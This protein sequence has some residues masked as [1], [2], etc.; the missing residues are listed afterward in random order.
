MNK[1][2]LGN[3]K[4][5][6]KDLMNSLLQE[7]I[8]G[9]FSVHNCSTENAKRE[10]EIISKDTAKGI[11]KDFSI[12]ENDYPFDIPE[13]WC[14]CRLRSLCMTDISYGIIKLFNED[15]NGVRVLRCSDV[16]ANKIDLSNVRT[17]SKKLSDE[18][19]RTILKGGEIVINVRG[20]LGGCSVVPQELEGYNVAREVAVIRP[21]ELVNAQY[22]TYLL[23]SPYFMEFMSTE[24]RGIAYKGLNMGILSQ[25]PVP[26]PPLSEQIRIINNIN[27]V[28]PFIQKFKLKENE[29]NNIDKQISTDL[30]NSILQEAI[31]G[32]L[33]PHFDREGTSD[34][35]IKE[36]YSNNTETKHINKKETNIEDEYLFDLPEN[37]RWIPLSEVCNIYTGDSINETE[38][39]LKYTNIPEGYP[40][41]GTKDVG[42]DHTIAYDNGVKIPYSKTNFSIAPA[43]SVLL[44][45]EGGS[46]GKKIAYTEQEVCFGNKL[47]CFYS[48][49]KELRSFIYYYLQSPV[50][51][52]VFKDN[53][54]GMIGGVSI[55][56]LRTMLLPL[57]P[58]AEQKRIVSAIE[59]LLPLCE[60]LGK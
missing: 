23:L 11:K 56:K 49:K 34:S 22:L 39:K 32:K 13:N 36:L 1:L 5:T 9:K 12:S 31:Q 58:L 57:P 41:I 47:C 25:F 20:T 6:A 29:L 53:I 16:K 3:Y 10:F 18:Y 50:F 42:F 28:T 27:K 38:K 4:M 48:L 19:S 45:I 2:S 8:H 55:G 30:R 40:Y 60:K 37:W 14:W 24:L 15:V 35:L 7:A 54:T 21:H 52:G 17:V 51:L 43:G 44:C 33:V 59:Q 26:L 46:A